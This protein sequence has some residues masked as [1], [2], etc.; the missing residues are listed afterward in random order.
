V[1]DACVD[2][3]RLLR[4]PP[5][6]G[7]ASG[8]LAGHDVTVWN[9]TSRM[10]T[11][12]RSGWRTRRHWSSS[13]SARPSTPHCSSASPICGSSAN[14]ASFPTR[15]RGV[16]PV[17]ASSVSSDLHQDGTVVATAELTWGLCRS[18]AAHPPAD[19][20]APGRWLAGERGELPRGQDVGLFGYGRIAPRHGGLRPGIRHPVLVWARPESASGR[21]HDGLEVAAPKECSSSAVTSSVHLRWR[22][23]P[24]HRH[25]PGPRP[26]APVSL[27]Q[28]QP[29]GLVGGGLAAGGHRRSAGHG[30]RRR[31][32]RG[33]HCD[34]EEPH[35]MRLDAVVVHPPH[36]VRHPGGVGTPVHRHLRQS[37]RRGRV[38]PVNVVNPDVLDG[39]ARPP[40]P[41][42][43]RAAPPLV[44]W[45]DA[46][47][48]GPSATRLCNPGGQEGSSGTDLG[49][50]GIGDR[51]V[52]RPI[53]SRRRLHRPR[54]SRCNPWC[55]R[56]G[57]EGPAGVRAPSDA[58]SSVDTATRLS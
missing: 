14:A 23:H 3:R 10:S 47:G 1:T 15:R 16:A 41:E 6:T 18:G 31:V 22:P 38:R 17:W 57:Q 11:H 32:R 7:G 13:A 40:P 5:D 51:Q 12:C 56:A 4:H 36:R 45:D 27:R 25:G 9:D 58:V 2:P 39:A 33:A 29:A 34:R 21:V 50:W 55:R 35:A 46:P 52:C 54:D 53:R 26:D 30:G 48:S 8:C 28:H 49:I 43:G 19:G 37:S 44:T 20:L 24:G 42:A